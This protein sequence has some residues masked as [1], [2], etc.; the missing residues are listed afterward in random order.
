MATAAAVPSLTADVRVDL[1]LV[2]ALREEHNAARL[3]A[4]GEK[5]SVQAFVARA[6]VEA[7]RDHPDLN[8]MFTDTELIRWSA[9]NLGFAVD[10]PGGLVV[11][12]I[13]DAQSLGVVEISAAIADLARKAREGTLESTDLQGGTFTIS[14]PGAVGPCLRAEALL[15]PPQTGLLGLPG[16][17][18]EPVVVQGPDGD[19]RVEIRSVMDPSLTFDHRAVDGGEAIR[20]LVGVRDRLQT[21]P[22]ADYLRPANAA[23]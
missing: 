14:N 2:L 15:N 17:R 5:A 3:A 10:A 12:V 11:P 19:E 6:A 9:V 1:G 8:A 22:L 16:L 23:G 18:R 21:W 4:G 13:R 20:F 7:L